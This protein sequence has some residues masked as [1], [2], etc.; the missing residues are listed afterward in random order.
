MENKIK[1]FDK[2]VNERKSEE[3]KNYGIFIYT[4]PEDETDDPV[5]VATYYEDKKPVAIKLA[6]RLMTTTKGL[7]DFFIEVWERPDDG[8]WGATGEPELVLENT[9]NE[10][11]NTFMGTTKNRGEFIVKGIKDPDIREDVGMRLY[12]ELADL[13]EKIAAEN[14]LDLKKITI[15]LK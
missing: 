2:F 8:M 15:E 1:S 10:S 14:N 3:E 11:K 13:T 9:I 7:D 4:K 6:K 12:D 5:C